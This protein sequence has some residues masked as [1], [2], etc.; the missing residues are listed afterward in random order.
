MSY[1]IAKTISIIT[2]AP[3][4]A[5]YLLSALYIHNK[6]I[7][8]NTALW[9]LI[10][11]LFLTAIPISAYGIKHLILPIKKQGRKGERKLAFI[12]AIAGYVLGTC[13]SFIFKAPE[14]V[15]LIFLAY[16]FSGGLLAFING[17]TNL[18]A[19]GHACGV[20]GPAALALYFF[21]LKFWWLLLLLIPVFYSKN[22]YGPSHLW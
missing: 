5:F 1:K 21:G 3:L 8:G 14:T 4:I 7:F 22:T 11:L 2:V 18:K 12:T 6:N 13:T 19:S 15:K 17:L 9:Y 10:C 20:A 16:L